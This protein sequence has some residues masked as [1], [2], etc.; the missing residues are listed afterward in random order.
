MIDRV[1]R[2]ISVGMVSFGMFILLF[3]LLGANKSS[4]GE[5]SRLLAR[6]MYVG[7]TILPD[8][9]L[10]PVVMVGDRIK[11]ATVSPEKRILLQVE[12]ANRRFDYATELL[13]REDLHFALG[14]LT[15]SQKYLFAA[16]G[17]IL[18]DPQAVDTTTHVAV[19]TA[20]ENSIPKLIEFQTNYPAEDGAIITDL[21]QESKVLL[22]QMNAASLAK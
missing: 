13:K 4:A 3:S 12:Y 7:R 17:E 2:N 20:L 8:H 11:L 5:S 1:Q 18:K 6:R 10:Y 22:L 21:V 19:R 9:V 16:T 14:T 15:K